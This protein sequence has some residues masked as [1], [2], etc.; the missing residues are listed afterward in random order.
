MV[1]LDGVGG[2]CEVEGLGGSALGWLRTQLAHL[3]AEKVDF[4]RYGI[5]LGIT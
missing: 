3:L 2:I 1:L 5:Q 4:S